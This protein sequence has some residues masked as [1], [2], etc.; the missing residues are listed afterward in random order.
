MKRFLSI[1]FVLL[2]LVSSCRFTSKAS[3]DNPPT[4]VAYKSIEGVDPNLLSLDIYT[5][6]N[7]SNAP[8]V[9][10]VHGGGYAIGDK[11]NQITDKV[12][13]FNGQG[14]I[15]VSVN[16]RLSDPNKRAAQYPD[17][18]LDVA[19]AVAW[20]REHIPTYG[21]DPKRIALLGHSAGADI[22]SNVAIN[23][24][25]LQE[26]GLELSA[27]TC[28]VPL[29]T[30]GFDKAKAGDSEQE[31]WAN[32][33]GNNPNYVAETSATLLIQPNI[34]IPPMLGVKRGNQSRQQIESEF[35]A[36]LQ[37]AGIEATLVDATSLSHEEVNAQ[38]G[39]A[40]DM[41]MTEALMKF[42]RGCFEQ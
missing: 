39:A 2:F 34:G 12:S 13:L 32:A 22:V 25:Y 37:A 21:G 38:I 23:P 19:A 42:L 9:M 3:L 27:L 17:H 14:W 29:D 20:V 28:A 24:I 31:Q 6:T 41:V 10:W 33:L 40:G 5:P 16:Y 35:I 26:Y 30:A 18:Y 11:S 4:T 8:V 1:S 15:L 7:A 36:A